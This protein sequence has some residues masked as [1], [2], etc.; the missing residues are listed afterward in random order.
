MKK[1]LFLTVVL[2]FLKRFITV[3]SSTILYRTVMENLERNGNGRFKNERKKKIFIWFCHG[4][5]IKK[6]L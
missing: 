1:S 4:K 5:K 2:S 6:T 3:P